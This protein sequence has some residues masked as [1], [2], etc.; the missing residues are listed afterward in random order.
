[1]LQQH[2]KMSSDPVKMHFDTSI[3]NKTLTEKLLP[4][5]SQQN[6]PRLLGP[7]EEKLVRPKTP[8]GKTIIVGASMKD[9]IPTPTGEVVV[10]LTS[11][12]DVVLIVTFDGVPMV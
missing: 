4:T 10:A 3:V 8:H 5:V 9:I 2:L 6:K 11:A 7:E 1:M 12:E